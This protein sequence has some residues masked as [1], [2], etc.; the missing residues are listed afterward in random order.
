MDDD[1][2]AFYLTDYLV[3]QFDKLIWQGL[4]LDRYPELRDM[5]FG[6]YE[7]VI[8]LAQMPTAE[9]EAQ[10]KMEGFQGMREY[11]WEKV[12]AGETTIAEVLSA[13]SSDMS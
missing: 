2:A 7:K 5:Y 12:I 8:Y 11:G 1:M 9:L 13:T 3:R 4:G 10:A 6:N